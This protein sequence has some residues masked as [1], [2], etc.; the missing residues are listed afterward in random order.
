VV[1]NS[2]FLILP[3]WHI[4]NLGSR[5][6]SLCQKRVARDWQDSFGHPVV[7]LET[8][9]DPQRFRGTVYRAANWLQVG[10]TKGF[11]RTGKGYSIERVAEI[12]CKQ[13]FR[14]R[15]LRRRPQL[16]VLDPLG[17][18]HLIS[19]R[20]IGSVRKN[21]PLSGLG[22]DL[23]EQRP[24]WAANHGPMWISTRGASAGIPSGAR[25]HHPG[26]IQ[27]ISRG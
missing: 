27:A 1:N 17:C 25:F 19:P 16:R 3:D 23:L 24:Q 4:P 8:F 13:P 9:V 21:L 26:G 10:L 11:R 22:A 2:R 12:Q 5:I 6:L 20:G 15:G 7:L 14:L 18:A